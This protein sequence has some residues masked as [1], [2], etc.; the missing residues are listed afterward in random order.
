[1]N[2][3]FIRRKEFLLILLPSFLAVVLAALYFRLKYDFESLEAKYND[4][5][6]RPTVNTSSRP[7]QGNFLDL[8]NFNIERLKE[9]GLTDPVR[10]IVAD[11]R[12]H[13]ELIPYEGVLGGQMG[14]YFDNKIWVLTDQ[15]VLAY[16][17]DGH[18][19][20]FLIAKYNVTAGGKIEWR[21]LAAHRI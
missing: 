10:D 3:Q 14:F 17:E 13:T 9:K 6:Q 11:L 4:V 2:Y 5:I 7:A 8:Q 20:G 16:F 21:R 1:M 18:A 12:K 19:G 15:W